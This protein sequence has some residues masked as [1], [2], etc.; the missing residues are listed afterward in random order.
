MNIIFIFVFAGHWEAVAALGFCDTAAYATRV[1]GVLAIPTPVPT[2]VCVQTI[3][4]K[5]KGSRKKRADLWGELQAC[6]QTEMQDVRVTPSY[7]LSPYCR[8]GP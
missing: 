6:Y 4:D 3:D 7:L 2:R 5:H 8:N 1:L